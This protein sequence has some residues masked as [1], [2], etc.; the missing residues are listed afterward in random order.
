MLPLSIG[1]VYSLIK[2]SMDE[3]VPHYLFLS[4]VILGLTMVPLLPLLPLPLLHMMATGMDG[5]AGSLPS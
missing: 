3:Y 2:T 4:P 1:L 5:Y